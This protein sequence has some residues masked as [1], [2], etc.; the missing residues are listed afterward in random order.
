MSLMLANVETTRRAR[1]PVEV[2]RLLIVNG[3][4]PPYH[5]IDVSMYI[6]IWGKFHS[7][8]A[9]VLVGKR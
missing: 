3:G 9:L 7:A 6:G 4:T 5:L 2:C 1:K 8:R